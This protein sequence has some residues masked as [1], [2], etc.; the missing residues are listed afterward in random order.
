[1]NL[2]RT[3]YVFGFAS[4]PFLSRINSPLNLFFFAICFNYVG[5]VKKNNDFNYFYKF[6]AS[7]RTECVETCSTHILLFANW[8]LVDSIHLAFGQ[9]FNVAKEKA[10]R[11]SSTVFVSVTLYNHLDVYLRARGRINVSALLFDTHTECTHKKRRKRN[12]VDH[13]CAA[14]H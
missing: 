10:N 11:I 7:I 2:P 9:W 14:Y 6:N 13:F 4:F 5:T 8:N 12:A 1:M 3:H